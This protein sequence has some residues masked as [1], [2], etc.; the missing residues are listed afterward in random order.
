VRYAVQQLNTVH[1]QLV[2]YYYCMCTHHTFTMSS[3]LFMLALL[4]S[5]CSV[6]MLLLHTYYSNCSE[7]AV[8]LL[9]TLF[10][11][12]SLFPHRTG[13]DGNHSM[14]SGLQLAA[15]IADTCMALPAQDKSHVMTL[16]VPAFLIGNSASGGLSD[17]VE[18]INSA[19]QG[20]YN[21]GASKQS[22][23][24]SHYEDVLR[25]SA[26]VV[27][28]VRSQFTLTVCACMS[29]ITAIVYTQ[30]YCSSTLKRQYMMLCVRIYVYMT[31]TCI[32]YS[33][34]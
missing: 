31:T 17:V 16:A 1:N 18:G 27:Q 19:L 32:L 28:W 21:A 10:D 25:A 6:C 8:L 26:R 15:T 12:Y 11:D 9:H 29:S 14:S 34:R 20:W 13:A 4:L 7:V 5:L 23:Q 22:Y 33:V 3:C 30:Y 24:W 2:K